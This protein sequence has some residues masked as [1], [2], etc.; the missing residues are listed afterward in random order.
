MLSSADASVGAG[1]APGEMSLAVTDGKIW[2]AGYFDEIL[3][4]VSVDPAT[5]DRTE[6]STS[7]LARPID[8]GVSDTRTLILV[9]GEQVVF[10]TNGAGVGVYDP[11]T[12]NSNWISM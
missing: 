8:N 7:P 3:P 9:Y 5:G 6:E 10:E 2:T 12:K 11:I 1:R 4:I